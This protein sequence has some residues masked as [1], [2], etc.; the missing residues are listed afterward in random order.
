MK[1]PDDSAPRPLNRRAVTAALLLVM[2]LASM[3]QTI[4]STA[5]PTIIGA[6]HGLEHYSWVASIYLLA[7][8]VSMPLIGR[9][10][11]SMGRKRVILFAIA[12]FA[13]SSTLAATAKTMPQLIVYRGLQG[14]GA[15]GIMPVVLTILGDIFTMEQ[16]AR[17][18]GLFSAVWGT[19][20]LAGPI[21]GWCLVTTLGW[22]SIFYVN[23]PLSIIAVVMLALCYHDQEKPHSVDLDLPGV[24]S[25]GLGCMTLLLLVSQLGPG[26][27][28]W[29]N[30]CVL[31]AVT[32]ALLAFFA[33]HESRTA[34]PV[35]P[36]DLLMNRSIGPALL[37]SGLLG[38]G[39]L[40][41]DTFVPLYVQ[42]GRGGGA[43]A[44]A[45]AVTPVMLTWALSGIVAAPLMVRW[46]F[47]RTARLGSIL[48]VVGFIGLLCCAFTGAPRLVLGIVLAITGLGF[49]PA[50]MSFLLAAQNAVD[51][52]RRGTV[53]SSIHFFRTVGGAMGI[54]ILGA[55]FNTITQPQLR[56]LQSRGITPASLLDPHM[57]EGLSPEILKQAGAMISGGLRWVFVVMLFV[58][59]L[60][61]IVSQW[62]PLQ[63]AEQKVGAL[64]AE[65]AIAG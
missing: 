21:L 20:S 11:D 24:L 26:G 5:M 19:A 54:G 52:Q 61:V 46:G 50:S 15:G 7:C 65:E 36:T 39:F 62:L 35:M 63:R 51:W 40:S 38:I 37:G 23:V 53:T 1:Q 13:F 57:R 32:A 16:R 42:G 10:A 58:S 31:A 28:S 30:S 17:V 27:W 33:F 12:L 59:V 9:L 8:T 3:E 43:G 34:H 47:R 64:K 44:A 25:L 60:Q 14:V 6:L 18:Q 56:T 49:G 45:W 55:L 41:L 48:V 4:T 2:V 29:E 22:P